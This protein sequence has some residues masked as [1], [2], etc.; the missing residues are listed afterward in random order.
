[1]RDYAVLLRKLGERVPKARLSSGAHLRD[2]SDF[3]QW[4][5]E[6]AA[7]AEK[8]ESLEELLCLI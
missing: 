8:A 3:V 7:K 5:N 1:M 2:A 4:L 6:L